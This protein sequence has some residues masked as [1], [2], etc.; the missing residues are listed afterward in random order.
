MKEIEELITLCDKITNTKSEMGKKKIYQWQYAEKICEMFEKELW[1]ADF[2]DVQHAY[3]YLHISK[4]NCSQNKNAVMF[5][6]KYH[7]DRNVYGVQKVYYLS[8]LKEKYPEFVEY[9]KV[10]GI[11]IGT[12]SDQKLQKIIKE[13]LGKPQEE[14]ALVKYKG[15]EYLIPKKILDKYKKI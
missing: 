9:A 10:N 13:F 6:R 3:D 11:D 15:D 5:D 2:P 4:A 12:T 14:M 1:K 7:F 8:T